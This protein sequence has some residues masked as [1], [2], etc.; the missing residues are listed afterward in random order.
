MTTNGLT[1]RGI[2]LGTLAT[3]VTLAL[4][5][6]IAQAGGKPI[7][8]VRAKSPRG[9]IR[10]ELMRMEGGVAALKVIEGQRTTG[11]RATFDAK[12]LKQAATGAKDGA[13]L[14]VSGRE[15][16]LEGTLRNKDGKWRCDWD[17]NSAVSDGGAS[18][19][20]LIFLFGT[21]MLVVVAAFGGEMEVAVETPVSS[22]EAKLSTEGHA[23]QAGKG[24]DDK[25]ED[26][27]DPGDENVGQGDDGA[28]DAD[29]APK[30]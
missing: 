26:E 12:A 18:A 23:G 11:V 19:A 3:G 24:G 8:V 25:D 22:F 13:W 5:P 30:P 16:Q 20:A 21:M 29:G 1:R 15:Q 4:D 6:K 7:A 28:Q 9:P 17:D 14:R 2:L 10:L 27:N